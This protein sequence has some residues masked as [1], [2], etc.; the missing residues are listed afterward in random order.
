[1]TFELSEKPDDRVVL[2]TGMSRGLGER[3]A[4]A[5]WQTG[6]DVFGT[7]RDLA[8][9]EALAGVLAA[10][11]VRVGQRIAVAA[12]DLRDASAPAAIVRECRDQ[13]GGLDVLISNA[14]VQGPI[15]K[16][17]EQD[18][19]RLEDA[20]EI[21]LL[22]SVRLAHAAIPIMMRDDQKKRSIVF[23]SGGGASGPRPGFGSYAAA[24]AGLVRFSETL[25]MKL[26]E[27]SIS[28]NCIA[29]GAMPTAM[30]AEVVAA[31]GDRACANEVAAFDQAKSSGE[32]VINRA[33]ALAI[34]LTKMGAGITGKLIAAQ[35][36]RWEDWP[37]HLDELNASDVYTLRRITGRDR[38][39]KWGDR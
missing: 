27:R 9:L 35:W 21:D 6:A 24:K 4:R 28:V 25:A 2:I 37:Q 16:F 33:A 30:L 5:F 18:L 17:W 1:M 7:A 23:L 34:F 31:G 10:A 13:L 22:A 19:A 20:L 29:P 15:G 26:R 14:A 39:K 38:N 32:A 11:P 3:L 36:D 12:A 8:A